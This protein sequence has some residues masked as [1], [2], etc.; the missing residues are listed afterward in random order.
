MLPR[1]E[2]ARDTGSVLLPNRSSGF[3]WLVQQMLQ[4]DPACRPDAASI[5][6]Q[7][8][9]L[10]GWVRPFTP[11]SASPRSHATTALPSPMPSPRLGDSPP[12]AKVGSLPSFGPVG[13]EGA[14]LPSFNGGMG[15]CMALDNDAEE[16]FGSAT[17]FGG[18]GRGCGEPPL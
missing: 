12:H 6:A 1:S 14:S 7:I 9:E 11:P 18:G 10:H 13:W 17:P 8:D 2:A 4:P 16:G 5:L 3:Q 15:G